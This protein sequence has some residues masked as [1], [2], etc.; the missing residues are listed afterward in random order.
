MVLVLL[1]PL[2]G[3]VDAQAHEPHEPQVIGLLVR[4]FLEDGVVH[5]RI[6]GVDEAVTVVPF[7]GDLEVMVVPDSAQ[8]SWNHRV[9]LG[10]ADPATFAD[11][12]LPYT[13][14]ILRAPFLQ[15]GDTLHIYAEATLDDGRVVQG[16]HQA[17]L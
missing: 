14:L 8:R 4:A 11:A 17:W 2:S 9:L 3:C 13:E 1:A 6:G 16:T 15:S 12:P 5:V 10:R 7:A